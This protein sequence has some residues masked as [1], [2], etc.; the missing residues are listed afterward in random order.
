MLT[1]ESEMKG[2]CLALLKK[3]T[4]TDKWVLTKQVIGMG[5][6]E[7]QIKIMSNNQH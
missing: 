2:V 5:G 7:K 4:L 3:W 6:G 1:T